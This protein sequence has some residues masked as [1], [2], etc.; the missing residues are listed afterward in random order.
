M[1]HGAAAW[2]TFHFVTGQTLLPSLHSPPRPGGD[3]RA[4]HHSSSTTESRPKGS[5]DTFGTS[6]LVDAQVVYGSDIKDPKLARE[7]QL[8]LDL[9]IE[10]IEKNVHITE[11]QRWEEGLGY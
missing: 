7:K 5:A 9:Q 8:K 6:T 4:P 3:G 1:I 10:E 11:I 2:E